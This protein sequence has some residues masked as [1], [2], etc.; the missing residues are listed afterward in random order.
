M[1]SNNKNSLLLITV[2]SVVGFMLYQ[3]SKLKV[4]L[5]STY[6]AAKNFNQQL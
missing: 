1:K 2:F 6:C 4:R 3:N 5:F